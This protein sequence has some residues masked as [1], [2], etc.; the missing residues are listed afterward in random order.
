[1]AIQSIIRRPTST[2]G[3]LAG[4]TN[5]GSML[6]NDGMQAASQT[7]GHNTNAPYLKLSECD[8][9]PVPLGATIVGIA[10]HIEARSEFTASTGFICVGASP[11]TGSG[12]LQLRG[13]TGSIGRGMT[14][15]KTNTLTTKI[16]GGDADLWGA[17]S[18]TPEQVNDPAFGLYA[19]FRNGNT[20]PQK[21]FIDHIQIEIFFD[22]N[23]PEPPIGGNGPVKPT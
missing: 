5:I 17:A 15:F 19:L 23:Q 7:T 6:L 2:A 16:I 22:D 12:G 13:I 18:I 1:M 3:S 14:A 4:W 8:G 20:T 21:M 9:D 10:V 11:A